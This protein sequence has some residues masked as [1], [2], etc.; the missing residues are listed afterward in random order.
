MYLSMYCATQAAEPCTWYHHNRGEEKQKRI[1]E[2]G[3]T[4]RHVCIVDHVVSCQRFFSPLFSPPPLRP[5]FFFFV[6]FTFCIFI[7]SSTSKS[8]SARYNTARLAFRLPF[9][10][11]FGCHYVK[12]KTPL[13]C[14]FTWSSIGFVVAMSGRHHA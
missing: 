8:L 7:S 2:H 3:T 11:K 10:V 13:T 6:F 5:V 1:A 4:E 12:E 14:V 9:H